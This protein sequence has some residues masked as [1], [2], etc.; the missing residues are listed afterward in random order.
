M[1]PGL[2][3]LHVLLTDVLAFHMQKILPGYQ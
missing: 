1:A 2:K 3:K